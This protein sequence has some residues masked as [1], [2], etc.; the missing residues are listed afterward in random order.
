LKFL[1]RVGWFCAVSWL[2]DLKKVG[3]KQYEGAFL[4]SAFRYPKQHWIG[5]LP[6]V[7]GKGKGNPRTGHEGP[8]GE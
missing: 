7:K 1:L 2:S 4:A 5:R 8:E 6:V 3:Q